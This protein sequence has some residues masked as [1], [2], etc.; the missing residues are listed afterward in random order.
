LEG[1]RARRLRPAAAWIDEEQVAGIDGVR[2]ALL[3]ETRGASVSGVSA[4]AW[5]V[6]WSIACERFGIEEEVL[7]DGRLRAVS[8]HA[9]LTSPVASTRVPCELFQLADTA[10]SGDDWGGLAGA[11]EPGRPAVA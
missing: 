8:H 7:S 1:H 2:S 10:L 9:E 3:G 5:S 11:A 6:R 4:T